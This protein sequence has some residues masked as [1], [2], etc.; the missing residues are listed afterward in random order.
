MVGKQPRAVDDPARVKELQQIIQG[1]KALRKFYE[2]IYETYAACMKSCP[3]DGLVVE[4]GSGGGFVKDCI[5]EV[6]TSDILPYEGVDRV[7]DGTDMPFEDETVRTLLMLNVFHHIPDVTAFLH[8]V[9]RV[10]K[11]G[12]RLLMVDQYSSLLSR[13]IYRFLHDEPFDPKAMDWSFA[14]SG[15]LSGANGAL[16][17]IVFERDVTR[18]RVEFP[19]LD[20]L[21]FRPHTPLRYWLAGGLKRWSLLPGWAFGLATLLDRGLARLSRQ[22]CSFVDVELRKRGN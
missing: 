17:W 4:L 1:K 7:I 12:G 8:E 16:A 19:E 9:C 20:L 5:P 11:P 6:V 10:L 13:P 18:F 22:F 15:P 21:S 14:S 2:E 3:E